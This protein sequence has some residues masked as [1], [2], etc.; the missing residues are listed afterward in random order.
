MI[1]ISNLSKYFYKLAKE[2]FS[3][4][5]LDNLLLFDE[6]EEYLSDFFQLINNEGG[7]RKVFIENSEKVIKVAIDNSGVEQN[8]NEILILENISSIL[9]PKLYNYSTHGMWLEVERITPLNNENDF[10]E[11]TGIDFDDFIFLMNEW[12]TEESFNDFINE[13]INNE[14]ENLDM[15]LKSNQWK[16]YK[17]KK[18]KSY[19]NNSFL[20]EFQNL[21]VKSHLNPI[22][23]SEIKNLGKSTSG[24]LVLLDLGILQ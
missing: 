1:S 3:F 19:L 4:E 6:M 11:L 23:F 24:N 15:T 8:E 22:E 7:S 5:H 2:Y 12:N 9:L 17:I 18:W 20:N 13:T 10:E 14:S 16:M 21:I